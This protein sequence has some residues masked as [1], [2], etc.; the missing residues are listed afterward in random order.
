MEGLCMGRWYLGL[1]FSMPSIS[2]HGLAIYKDS[3]VLLHSWLYNPSSVIPSVLV[4]TVPVNMLISSVHSDTA[5][6]LLL[7]RSCWGSCVVFVPSSHQVAR[8]VGETD[9]AVSP[10]P[11]TFL[12]GDR[13]FHFAVWPGAGRFA[14]TQFLFMGNR[15]KLAFTAQIFFLEE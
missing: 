15:L 7:I 10:K 1:G 11:H 14:E 6:S 4:S 9:L 12:S 8:K 2:S 3:S 13:H 5:C